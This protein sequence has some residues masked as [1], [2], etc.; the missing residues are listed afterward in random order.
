MRRALRGF[1]VVLLPALLFL[2]LHLPALDYGLVWTDE[3]EIVQGTILRAKGSIL[4]AFAEPMHAIADFAA[5]PFSQPYYRPL[6]VVTASLLAERFGREPRVFRTVTLLL[7][8]ITASLFTAL[9]WLV[10]RRSTAALLAGA[11]IAFQQFD[12]SAMARSVGRII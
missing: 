11:P 6:Q 3:P 12:G 5:S 1:A 10:L 7:G 2:A 4:H 8:A 9:A